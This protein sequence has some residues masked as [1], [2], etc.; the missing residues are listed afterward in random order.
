MSSGR[1]EEGGRFDGASCGVRFQRPAAAL[2]GG[3]SGP[4]RPSQRFGRMFRWLL[5]TAVLAVGCVGPAA[6]QASKTA[7]SDT[8]VCRALALVTPEDPTDLCQRELDVCL[9]APINRP[10]AVRFTELCPTRTNNKKVNSKRLNPDLCCVSCLCFV[11]L[12]YRTARQRFA[13]ASPTFT[14][15]TTTAGRCRQTT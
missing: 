9:N 15:A 4:A 12:C 1:H 8:A 11:F 7:I 3:P 5:V 13:C 6:A 14:C 10:P 2:T